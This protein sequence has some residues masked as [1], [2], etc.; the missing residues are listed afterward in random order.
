[1][2]PAAIS[3]TIDGT[4][5]RAPTISKHDR[6]RVHENQFLQDAVRRHGRTLQEAISSQTSSNPSRGRE[7]QTTLLGRLPH[8]L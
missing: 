5:S 8:R 7:N 1:M 2:T 3:A 6:E 4:R